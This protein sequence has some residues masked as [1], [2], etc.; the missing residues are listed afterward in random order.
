MMKLLKGIVRHAVPPDAPTSLRTLDSPA[1]AKLH[2]LQML[3]DHNKKDLPTSLS[4]NYFTLL[5]GGMKT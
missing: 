4:A 3:Y 1:S 5:E 2:P